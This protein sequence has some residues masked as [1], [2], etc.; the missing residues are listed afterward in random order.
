MKDKTCCF[1]GHRNLPK[2]K[3]QHIHNLLIKHILKLSSM[4]I[5]NY[6]SG[7]A[8]GFDTLAALA[9]IKIRFIYPNIKLILALPSPKQTHGW[10]A[11]DIA[12]YENI[13]EHANEVIYTSQQHHGGCMHI[14][15]HYMVD[16]SKFCI[17]YME[18]KSGGTAYTVNYAYK[19]DL[20]VINL[21]NES[22]SQSSLFY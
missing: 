21:A 2:N 7:G 22:Q 20:F 6:I 13:V 4:G 1:S 9:V 5:T 3:I 8:L 17:C 16:H 11:D 14:R 18:D 10:G 19:K 12:L 15:N